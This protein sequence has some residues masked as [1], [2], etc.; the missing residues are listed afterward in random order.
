[1]T[2]ALKPETAQQIDAYIAEV[3]KINGASGT[4]R[5]FT[6]NPTVAQNLEL[7][8]QQSSHFLS[9][10]NIVRVDEQAGDKLGLGISQPIAYRTAGT[11]EPVDPI[12][13]DSSG[14][15]CRKTDFDTHI[16]YRRLD[17]WAKF[18]NFQTLLRDAILGQIGRDRIMIGWNG[19]SAADTTNRTA[20]PLLQD[21]NIGWIQK[22]RLAAP[23]R[24]MSEAIHGTGKVR[25]G[26]TGDYVDLDALIFDLLNNLIDPWHRNAFQALGFVVVMSADLNADRLFPLVQA[27]NPPSEMMAADV[28][29][30]S[31]KAGGLPVVHV[32]YFPAKSLL[33]TPLN[34]LSIYWQAGTRRRRIVDNPARDRIEDYQS[35]NEAY[36]IEDMGKCAFVENIQFV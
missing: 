34:N 16:S 10:I 14:Y 8:T 27:V 19:T 5:A 29:I 11:R 35:V 36:V 20:N 13:L 26:W 24:V 23:A 2:Y 3:K 30:R 22:L 15:L 21:V 32:P 1:M 12:V 9:T 25:I 28:I 7:Q 31:G 6:V 17:E 4:E 33:I 18:P